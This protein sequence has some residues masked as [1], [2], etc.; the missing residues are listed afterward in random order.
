[1]KKIIIF[2]NK[3]I[4]LEK[5]NNESDEIFYERINYILDN[6]NNYDNLNNLINQSYFYIN[7]KYLDCSYSE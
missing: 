1:M 5:N 2:K 4:I 6:I 7:T 3:L